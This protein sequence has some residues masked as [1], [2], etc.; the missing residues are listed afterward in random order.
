MKLA[1]TGQEGFI[2]SHLYNTIRHKRK[3][4]QLVD[5]SKDFFDKDKSIDSVL[6]NVDIIV[7][8]AGVNRHDDP[9]F[10]YNQNIKLSQ[11]ILDSIKRVGFTGHLIFASSTQENE[12]NP[13]GN[14]KKTSR[15]LFDKE[16]AKNGYNFSGLIIPNVFGPFTK[17]NYNSFIATFCYNSI[18]DIENEIIIDSK[19]SLIY[20]ETLINK[21]IETFTNQPKSKVEVSNETTINVSSVKNLIEE[22]KD[23]YLINGAIPKLNTKF[24][25][26]LFKTFITYIPLQDFFPKRYNLFTDERGT[27][28]ELVRTDVP[29]QVSYSITKENETRG[30]H[31]HTRKIERFSVISGESQIQIRKINSDEIFE[32]KLSGSNPSYIDMPI[33]H[34]H[35]IKNIGSEP[36]IT[37]FW[38]NEFYDDIDSDT[39]Y[40]KV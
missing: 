12:D 29:G 4:I 13:Y 1:I 25:K 38:I 22:F 5:F 30:N 28:S 37:V 9:S 21:I 23:T 3:D 2:G 15:K 32:F 27:F 14:A 8:L 34:T 35:N 19:V 20:V 24:K 36:L 6:N 7:H 33:W 18:R 26:D 16:S 11:K 39:F 17:P 40:E 10:L 31:F